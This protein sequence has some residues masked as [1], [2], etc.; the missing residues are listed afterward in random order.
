MNNHPTKL[1]RISL[2][3]YFSNKTKENLY[4]FSRLEK[5]IIQI[6]IIIRVN[7]QLI[8][9][10]KSEIFCFTPKINQ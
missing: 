3:L 1:L 10:H 6:K 4:M 8:T 9:S 7:N 2:P 5:T